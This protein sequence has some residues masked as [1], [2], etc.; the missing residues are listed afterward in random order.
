MAKVGSRNFAYTPQGMKQANSYSKRT[1]L[2]Q[3]GGYASKT[4][5]ADKKGKITIKTIG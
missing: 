5:V 2:K 1:G 3:E 4:V